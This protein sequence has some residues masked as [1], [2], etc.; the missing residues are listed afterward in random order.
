MLEMI[1]C[2]LLYQPGNSSYEVQI[3]KKYMASLLVEDAK[4]IT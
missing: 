2:D 3:K 4:D 1:S